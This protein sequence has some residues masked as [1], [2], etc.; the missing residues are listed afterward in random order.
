MHTSRTR[1][2]RF[3]RQLAL[4]AL[5]VLTAMQLGCNKQEMGDH[6]STA[7]R[8][9][10]VA[11]IELKVSKVTPGTR[12]GEEIYVAVC[13][14]CHETGAL[15]AP[16]TGDAAAWAPRIAQGLDTMVKHATEGLRAMPPRGGGADLTDTEMV[17]AVA[18]LANTAGGNFTE[19]P[20][21]Q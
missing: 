6:E 5:A 18:Y 8:I 13:K 2:T 7:M 19:P 9:Q 16:K 17:R 10:P 1:T 21:A 14:G 12:T 11:K 20:V 15:D 4:P 3:A